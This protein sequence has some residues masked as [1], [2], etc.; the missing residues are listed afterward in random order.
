ML[1]L[2]RVHPLTQTRLDNKRIIKHGIL[3]RAQIK[4]N[5]EESNVE[6]KVRNN[7]DRASD[8]AKCNYLLTVYD[9]CKS[10]INIGKQAKTETTEIK[11]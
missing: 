11:S 2:F 1:E 6:S 4:V 10:D 7:I 5:N 8:A 3:I 9:L